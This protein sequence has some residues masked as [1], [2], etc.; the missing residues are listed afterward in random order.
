MLQAIG[1]L[2]RIG[3]SRVQR[4]TILTV[5]HT[6]DQ[7]LQAKATVKMLDQISEEA[8]MEEVEEPPIEALGDAI[9]EGEKTKAISDFK[10][11]IVTGQAEELVRKMLGQRTS[12]KDWG[13]VLD[14]RAKDSLQ[15]RHAETPRALKKHTLEVLESQPVKRMRM[16]G[17]MGKS[18]DYS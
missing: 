6:Y 9:T 4:I 15:Y 8:N 1:R 3:Q 17:G 10:N 14:L 7:V 5:D 11:A 12:R 2:H 18:A 16:S 13:N